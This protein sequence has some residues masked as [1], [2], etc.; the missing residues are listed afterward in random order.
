MATKDIADARMK[1]EAAKASAKASAADAKA[2]AAERIKIAKAQKL[3]KMPEPTGVA[4]VD[5]K[6]DLDEVQAGF[7]RRAAAEADRFRLVTDS[8]YWG[9]LCFQTREQRDVFFHALG[10]LECGDS[11]YYDGVAVAKKLGVAIP[12]AKLNYRPEPKIDPTWSKFVK[13]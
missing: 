6:A 12:E 9:V 11:R 10:L 4:E 1:A 3:V 5:A 7:R 8:E 13:E 2:K